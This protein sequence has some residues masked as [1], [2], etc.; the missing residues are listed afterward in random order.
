MNK[1]LK[2]DKNNKTN[3]DR[4]VGMHGV[5]TEDINKNDI[6]EVKVDGKR[7]S[8]ISKE[9]LEKGTIVNILKIDGVKLVV[10]KKEDDE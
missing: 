4:V 3:L 8:A 6:G 10:S 7:W 2:K 1:W 5:V 9:K